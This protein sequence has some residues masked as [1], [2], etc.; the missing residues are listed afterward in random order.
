MLTSK[1]PAVC[2]C[3]RE[4]PEALKVATG[5]VGRLASWRLEV[6][7]VVEVFGTV[8]G[9]TARGMSWLDG[10]ARE[11]AAAAAVTATWRAAAAAAALEARVAGREKLCRE[12]KEPVEAPAEALVEMPEDVVAAVGLLMAR[13]EGMVGI[14]S[15]LASEPMRRDRMW[16]A[17][18]GERW[19]G[20][21]GARMDEGELAPA[22]L[23]GRSR[24]GEGEE[25]DEAAETAVCTGRGEKLPGPRGGREGCMMGEDGWLSRG[26]SAGANLVRLLHLLHGAA[27][28][29][30]LRCGRLSRT[31]GGHRLEDCCFVCL[32]FCLSVFSVFLFVF[33][34]FV[35]FCRSS[36]EGQL[37]EPSCGGPA[38][39]GDD[40]VDQR[41]GRQMR[42]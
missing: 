33:S 34:F 30:R 11:D 6:V 8:R 29:R 31:D 25:E 35:F 9:E 37:L 27:A 23:G 20:R 28:R 1:R 3:L 15:S 17:G 22:G 24:V 38:T 21:P 10:A 7:V 2:E 14:E 12:P 40:K 41:I 18:R 36:K 19:T 42:V 26:R 32:S 16:P 39:A 5:L 4:W 13:G